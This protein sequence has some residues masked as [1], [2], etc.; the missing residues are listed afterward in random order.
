MVL[1]FPDDAGGCGPLSL[2]RSRIVDHKVDTEVS[3][4]KVSSSGTLVGSFTQT[5]KSFRRL[6]NILYQELLTKK[7]FKKLF[8]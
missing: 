5:R 1:E 4:L 2:S 6:V 3:C 7:S 8:L